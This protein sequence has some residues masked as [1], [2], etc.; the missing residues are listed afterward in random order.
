MGGFLD[1]DVGVE[2]LQQAEVAQFV[3]R[4]GLQELDLLRALLEAVAAGIGDLG[5]EMRPFLALGGEEIPVLGKLLG[6]G[7]GWG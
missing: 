5:V 4:R 3:E 1:V 7:S 2:G 6:R